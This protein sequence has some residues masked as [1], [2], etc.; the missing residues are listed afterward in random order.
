MITAHLTLYFVGSGAR[1][2]VPGS[3]IT[4]TDC[5]VQGARIEC[6][7]VLCKCLGLGWVVLNA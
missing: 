7:N 1:I 4:Y 5:G 6:L 2:V 3:V